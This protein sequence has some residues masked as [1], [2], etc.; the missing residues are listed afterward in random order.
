MRLK[1]NGD[2]ISEIF[3]KFVSLEIIFYTIELTNVNGAKRQIWHMYVNG[4]KHQILLQLLRKYN[5]KLVKKILQPWENDDEDAGLIPKSFND[6]IIRTYDP[7]Q[8]LARI[9]HFTPSNVLLSFLAP[10]QGLDQWIE[11][12]ILKNIRVM[13]EL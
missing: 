5:L 1:V 7:H 4:N 3:L 13:S 6:K 11:A 9:T 10:E 2:F 12:R 8:I